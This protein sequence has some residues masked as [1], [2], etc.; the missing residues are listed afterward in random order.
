MRGEAYHLIGHLLQTQIKLRTMG[1]K[2]L[3][4]ISLYIIFVKFVKNNKK[5]NSGALGDFQ[6]LNYFETVRSTF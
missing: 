5:Q 2:M 6:L 1:S 3:L 4:S